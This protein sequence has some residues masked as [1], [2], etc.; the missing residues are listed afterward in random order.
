MK[1]SHPNMDTKK[2]MAGVIQVKAI[3]TITFPPVRQLRY[4]HM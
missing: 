3:I 2:S 4:L 1:C